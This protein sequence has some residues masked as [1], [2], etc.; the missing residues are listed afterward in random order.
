[1]HIL[2]LLVT[3]III[4][5]YYQEYYFQHL[6]NTRF[7]LQ[8]MAERTRKQSMLED[9]E[10]DDL[11]SE[12]IGEFGRWQLQLTFLLS[13]FNIPCTWHIFAPTFQA[14]ERQSWCIQFSHTSVDGIDVQK[15]YSSDSCSFVQSNIVNNLTDGGSVLFS[16]NDSVSK[17]AK[18]SSWEFEGEGNLD[19][20]QFKFV[21]FPTLEAVVRDSVLCCAVKRF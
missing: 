8:I 16:V 12:A 13:L 15:N 5:S 11:I 6:N 1:M 18:C 10:D 17:V 14:A 19:C 20:V 3:R 4:G 2:H 9:D 7:L 21:D